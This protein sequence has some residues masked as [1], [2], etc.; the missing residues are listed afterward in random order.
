MNATPCHDPADDF[1]AHVRSHYELVSVE[2][3]NV[4]FFFRPEH[5]L[6]L[7]GLL[8]DAADAVIYR[9]EMNK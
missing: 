1:H 4:W 8:M 7:A 6:K 9:K 3:F 5:A 2:Y